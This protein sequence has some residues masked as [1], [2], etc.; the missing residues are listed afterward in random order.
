[1]SAPVITIRA[2]DVVIPGHEVAIEVDVTV[3]SPTKVTAIEIRLLGL[4]A[5][6]MWV[7]D[8]RN[9]FIN[10][11]VVVHGRG[12]LA[13]GKHSFAARFEL[14]ADAPPTYDRGDTYASLRA[15]V[16]ITRGL[17]A[18]DI[19][20]TRSIEVRAIVDPPDPRPD[21]RSDDESDPGLV[22]NVASTRLARGDVL[23]GTITG[24]GFAPDEHVELD[25]ALVARSV[26][27][28]VPRKIR[29]RQLVSRER[30]RQDRS[31][32]PFAIAISQHEPP[33]LRC[34][35]HSLYW[36]LVVHAKGPGASRS[37]AIPLEIVDVD[38]GRLRASSTTRTAR[39]EDMFAAFVDR[40][41]WRWDEAGLGSPRLSVMRDL[42]PAS[43][44][45][46][47]ASYL[48]DGPSV[49]AHI[50]YPSL[51]LGL[52]VV[53]S[54]PLRERF[55]RGISAHHP[56]WDRLHH[57]TATDEARAVEVLRAIVPA[58]VAASSLGPLV[59]WTDN[60][61]RFACLTVDPPLDVMTDDLEHIASAIAAVLPASHHDGVYR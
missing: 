38:P 43:L 51:E 33:S 48:P 16:T 46:A 27:V 28:K 29:E 59:Q 54:T 9:H 2:P 49:I 17:L 12:S 44:H 50:K 36:S 31:P 10:R 15:I 58:V 42:G 37:V 25:L 3:R 35:T 52:E 8:E 47:F 39:L 56:E 5:W 30:L 13:P 60:E 26:G 34:E 22:V 23:R 14:D 20:E 18:A 21:E 53:S 24:A 41:V 19:R 11:G 1:M 40:S 4:D 45:L 55:R 7:G 61:I 57:V 6:Q 32:T